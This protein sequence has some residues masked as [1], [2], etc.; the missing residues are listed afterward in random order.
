MASRLSSRAVRVAILS[1]IWDLFRDTVSGFVD[2]LVKIL[3]IMASALIDMKPSVVAQ[4]N[5]TTRVNPDVKY[6]TWAGDCPIAMGI[7]AY[8]KTYSCF[9]SNSF[10]H[11]ATWP[12]TI[13]YG[14][15]DCVINVSSAK[16]DPKYCTQL[17]VITGADQS[18]SIFAI[19][20]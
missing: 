17:G 1:S 9:I 15:T 3:G 14:A 19:R 6:F 8:V 10:E 11:S 7:F 13:P 2:A 4:F 20:D 5:E 18:V 12:F 16:W